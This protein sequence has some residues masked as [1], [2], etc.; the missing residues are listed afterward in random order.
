[1]LNNKIN[2]YIYMDDTIKKNRQIVLKEYLTNN[3][4]ADL[5]FYD[6]KIYHRDDS[7]D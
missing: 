3:N 1:M 7:T 4:T 2:E 5:K 6:L